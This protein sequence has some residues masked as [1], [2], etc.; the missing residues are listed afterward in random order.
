MIHIRKSKLIAATTLAIAGAALV[1]G[2]SPAASSPASASPVAGSTASANPIAAASTSDTPQA[3]TNPV[4][5]MFSNKSSF[6][7]VFVDVY[8]AKDGGGQ[9][10]NL[11]LDQGR[12][13]EIVTGQASSGTDMLG[14]VV[15]PSG[16]PVEFKI[17]NPMFARPYVTLNG[18]EHSFSENEVWNT[19]QGCQSFSVT[20]LPDN[21]G[22]KVFTFVIL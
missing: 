13:P 15:Y 3:M 1:V 14:S 4:T 10:Y 12:A 16:D 2:F 8:A 17:K 22:T 20:R 19:T 7:R 9:R 21:N 5:T 18:V 11:P 6:D